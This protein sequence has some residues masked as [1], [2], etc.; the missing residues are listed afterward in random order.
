MLGVDLSGH[1][2]DAPFPRHLINFASS[3]S[4]ASRFKLII[5]IVDREKPTL[6]QC[7][8]PT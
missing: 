3:E 1:D 4:Q 8:L 2:L 7:R 5:D 6:R